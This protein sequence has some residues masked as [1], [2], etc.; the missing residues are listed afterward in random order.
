MHEIHLNMDTH[1]FPR[2]RRI[3]HDVNNENLVRPVLMIEKMIRSDDTFFP[4]SYFILQDYDL[5]ECINYIVVHRYGKDTHHSRLDKSALLLCVQEDPKCGRF[6][7][8]EKAIIRWRRQYDHFFYIQKDRQHCMS[9]LTSRTTRSKI[10][11]TG[12][13]VRSQE[14]DR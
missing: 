14:D 4:S 2:I 12:E 11:G 5:I 3:S 10:K 13:A 9:Q 6:N 8:V 1:Q 7:R